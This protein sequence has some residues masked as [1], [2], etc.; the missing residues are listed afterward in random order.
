MTRTD[1]KHTVR[2]DEAD[3]RVS[4]QLSEVLLRTQWITHT[5]EEKA[6][7][8]EDDDERSQFTESLLERVRSLEHQRSIQ[9]SSLSHDE[10]SERQ[11]SFKKAPLKGAFLFLVIF[12]VHITLRR[13][14]II[15]TDEYEYSR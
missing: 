8:D 15:H 14:R 6:D 12:C 3:G 10:E 7:R 1:S 2:L 13:D 4:D 5:E 11:D 9:T